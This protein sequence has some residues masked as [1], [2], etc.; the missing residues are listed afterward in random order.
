M[1]EMTIGGNKYY[2]A[3][4]YTQDA[5]RNVSGKGTTSDDLVFLLCCLAGILLAAAVIWAISKCIQDT[6]SKLPVVSVDAAKI[7]SKTYN[8]SVGM[9][10]VFENCE[11]GERYAVWGISAAERTFTVGDVGKLTFL[12]GAGTKF[13]SKI[14]SFTIGK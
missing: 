6:Q 14:V 9:E 13:R 10:Y 2:V 11:T 3:S 8:S 4:T 1:S 12:N 5:F 7:I